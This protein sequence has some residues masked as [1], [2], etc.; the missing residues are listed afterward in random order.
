[1]KK[2]DASRAGAPVFV[3]YP[4][5]DAG[6]YASWPAPG[7]VTLA[8]DLESTGFSTGGDNAGCVMERWVASARF[9]TEN[10][11]CPGRGSIDQRT[12]VSACGEV[13]RYTLSRFERGTPPP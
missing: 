9:P 1:V 7:D 10:W 3:V 12:G 13:E 6:S 2:P 4:R 5:R 11:M 8:V